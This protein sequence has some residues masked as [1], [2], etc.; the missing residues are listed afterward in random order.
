MSNGDRNCSS[1]S[2]KNNVMS[3]F[4]SVLMPKSVFHQEQSQKSDTI[5]AEGFVKDS[6]KCKSSVSQKA[7]SNVISATVFS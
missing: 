1:I 3:D 6:V 7:Q 5:S 4:I 2:P